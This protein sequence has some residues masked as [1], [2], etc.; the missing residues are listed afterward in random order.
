MVSA[1]AMEEP[2]IPDIPESSNRPAVLPRVLETKIY[3]LF[4]HVSAFIIV[5]L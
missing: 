5:P 4:G 3:E 1:L 2:A